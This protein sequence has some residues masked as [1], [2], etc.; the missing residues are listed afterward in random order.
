MATVHVKGVATHAFTISP[1]DSVLIK[2]DAANDNDYEGVFVYT[3]TAGNVSVITANGKTINFTS[4]PA[5]TVLG[6]DF[7]I[8]VK[9]VRTTGTTATCIALIPGNG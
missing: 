4:V 3:A 9:Q 1:S 6:G 7:P 2:D 8:M 5:F